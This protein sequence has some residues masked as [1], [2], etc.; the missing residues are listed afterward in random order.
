MLTEYMPQL[1]SKSRFQES[2]SVLKLMAT[3]T[4]VDCKGLLI[5]T[6]W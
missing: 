4:Q 5:Y 1:R 2:D 6:L 3:K